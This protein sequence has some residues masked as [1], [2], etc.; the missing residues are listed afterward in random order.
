MEPFQL[1]QFETALSRTLTLRTASQSIGTLGEKSLH[2]VL[3]RYYQSDETLHERKVGRM[4][5]D[6]VLSDGSI[7]EIQTRGF[8]SLRK[9]LPL[10][11]SCGKV[12]LVAPVVQKKWI[13]WLDPNTGEVVSRRRSPKQYFPID[14]SRELSCIREFLPHPNLSIHFP[15]LEAEEY[16]LL[17]GW[18]NG[19]KRGSTRYERIP[20]ALLEEWIMTCPQDYAALFP[21]N[22]PG[23]FTVKELEKAARIS[24]M[25]AYSAA[26]VFRE[27]GLIQAIGKQGRAVVYQR[28]N[29][30]IPLTNQG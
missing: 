19:G 21:A 10:L 16:R 18:G 25:C 13:C 8:S 17:D 11:L 9:K 12:H 4:A 28:K 26:A 24:S 30:E 29:A 23:T 15:L 5:V 14:L 1:S 7:L 27:L 22:L 6:A 20:L 3:K 2:A